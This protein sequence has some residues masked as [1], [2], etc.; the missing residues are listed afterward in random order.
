MVEQCAASEVIF[1]AILRD[2]AF[3]MTAHISK[4]LVAQSSLS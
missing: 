4:V 1:S 3:V 2:P